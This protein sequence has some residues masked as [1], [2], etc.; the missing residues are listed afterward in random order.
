VILNYKKDIPQQEQS[1]IILPDNEIEQMN[2]EQT[3]DEIICEIV[4]QIKNQ[5]P[6]YLTN[7]VNQRRTIPTDV[8]GVIDLLMDHVDEN[9]NEQSIDTTNNECK[10]IFYT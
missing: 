8:P 1:L 9:D 3:D 4:E 2:I 5:I 6:E 7:Q 10:H